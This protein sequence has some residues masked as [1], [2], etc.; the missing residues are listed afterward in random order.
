MEIIHILPKLCTPLYVRS[1]MIYSFLVSTELSVIAAG[2]ILSLTS[3][4][5]K[6]LFDLVC[7]YHHN[8][9]AILM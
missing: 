8:N 1:D 6:D 4:E 7:P 2:R 5:K 3:D 9:L